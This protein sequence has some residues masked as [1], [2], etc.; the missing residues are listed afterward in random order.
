MTPQPSLTSVVNAA[1]QPL[2]R[3]TRQQQGDNTRDSCL[4]A[5]DRLRQPLPQ[6]PAVP[7]PVRPPSPADHLS[8]VTLLKDDLTILG[9]TACYA[10]DVAQEGLILLKRATQP[11]DPSL[12]VPGTSSLTHLKPTFFIFCP[13]R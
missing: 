2:T 4:P 12:H 9:F 1:L 10:P 11:G 13:R 3:G 6:D 8:R 5:F 7:T